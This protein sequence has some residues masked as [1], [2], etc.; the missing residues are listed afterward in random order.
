MIGK[1]IHELASYLF[2]LNRSITGDGVRQTLR[3]LKEIVPEL[4]IREVKT[5]TKVFDWTVP[6]EWKVNEAFIIDPDGKKFCDFKDNNLHLIGYSAFFKNKISLDELQP[7]LYS[8]EELPEAIPYIT[9]YYSDNWGFCISQKQRDKLKKGMYEVVIDT[10]HF[11]GSLTYGEILLEGKSKK[12]I[13]ISTYVCHP[14]MA[15]NELSGPTVT[16]FLAKWLKSL[17]RNYSYRIIFIPET[18]GSLTYLSLNL[19]QMK[20]Q[21][22]AGFNINCVGDD[23]TYSFMASKKGDTLPD[24]VARHV[25]KHIYPAYETYDWSNR[26]SD[27]RQYCSPGIDLPVT[28]IYRSK[29]STYPEYHTSLD[30]LENVVTPEGLEGGYEVHRL[31]LEILEKNYFPKVQCL[32][33]PNLGSRGLYPTISDRNVTDTNNRVPTILDFITWSDGS[34]SLLDIADKCDLPIWELYDIS[35]KLKDGGLIK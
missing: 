20:E 10:E 22:I 23:R 18:I 24:K 1:Q 2:P 8:L 32:G 28:S 3:S 29:D 14:S 16:I 21:I 7:N 25:L 33:E 17:D 15:N 34:H 12:E 19:A 27:E 13:F 30:D 4:E 6:K 9:S 5:G 26:G 35:K 31:A 11:E